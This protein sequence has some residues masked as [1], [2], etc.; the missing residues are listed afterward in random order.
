MS[1]SKNQIMQYMDQLFINQSILKKW[2]IFKELFM[3]QSIL[4]NFKKDFFSLQLDSNLLNF[5]FSKK[6]KTK[7]KQ[8]NKKNNLEKLENV[9][10]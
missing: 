3:H 8:T 7:Q 2:S 1:P 10:K 5:K 9:K 4:E 6:T